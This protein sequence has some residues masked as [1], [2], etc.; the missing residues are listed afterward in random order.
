MR[1]TISLF[2]LLNLSVTSIFAKDNKVFL[3]ADATQA[4]QVR[5][6]IIQQAKKE[7]LVEYFSIWNDQQ[8]LASLSFLI[9]AAQRG[10]K[11][12]IIMDALSSTVPRPLMNALLTKGRDRTGKQNLEIKLYNPIS[13]NLI[14]GTHRDHAKMILVDGKTVLS[15]GRNLGDKYFGKNPERNFTDLDVLIEGSVAQEVQKNFYSVWNSSVVQTPNLFENSE[16]KMQLG[17][18]SPSEDT[19]E[20]CEA[21]RQRALKEHAS[22]LARIR[23]FMESFALTDAQQTLK[24]DTQTNWLQSVDETNVVTFLSHDTDSL[25]NK[26]N[27]H[28]TND[29]MMALLMAEQEIEIISPYLIPTDELFSVFQT[30]MNRGVK[31]KILT[32]SLRSTDN[33]FAQAGYRESKK[34]LIAMGLEIYE[35]NGIDTLHAKAAL[36]DQ[37]I[38]FVGTYNLDPRSSFLNREIGFI[39]YP[40]KKN[41]LAKDLHQQFI[42]FQQNSFLV[43]KDGLEYNKS[44]EF[45]GIS[46]FKK[47]LLQSMILLMPLFREQI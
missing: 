39:I 46:M 45:N 47:I 16:S 29:L 26:S 12:K 11:V 35:Y 42:W 8:S 10:V 28:M 37:K 32:N 18:C 19:F 13:L 9:E 43:G 3:V 6:D 5:I 7:I 36:I 40:N 14:N 15:G 31:V 24:K 2:F 22:E 21:A 41:Q 20:L 17:A 1:L 38:V 23:K 44:K 27:N 4:L 30:L 25:V 33:L 34:R